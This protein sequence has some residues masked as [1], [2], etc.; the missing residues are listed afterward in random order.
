[1]QYIIQY[2]ITNEKKLE[3]FFEISDFSN[4]NSHTQH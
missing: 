2:T 1:M 3:Y 4:L